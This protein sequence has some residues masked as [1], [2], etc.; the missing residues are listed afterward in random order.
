MAFKC[1]DLPYA[2]LDILICASISGFPSE[3]SLNPDISL[4]KLA[5]KSIDWLLHRLHMGK[6]RMLGA[7]LQAHE[8]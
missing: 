5:Q 4:G 1:N 2:K 3:M 7:P 8:R 6:L